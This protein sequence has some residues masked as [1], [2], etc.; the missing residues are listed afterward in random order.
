[1]DK[2]SFAVG[3]YSRLNIN[4]WFSF[5]VIFAD[6]TKPTQKRLK[7]EGGVSAQAAIFIYS[8]L[9]LHTGSCLAFPKHPTFV[10]GRNRS[11][12]LVSGF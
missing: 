12:H 4:M 7:Q 9:C 8:P 5:C 10:K 11:C 1:M 6:P 2:H 3:N